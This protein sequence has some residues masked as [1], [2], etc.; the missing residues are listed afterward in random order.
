MEK[1]ISKKDENAVQQ[2]EAE[3]IGEIRSLIERTRGTV[4]Q[5]V[6]SALVLMNWHI[7]KR[8]NDEIL[9]NK[10]AD[11]GEKI[12]PTLSAQ[13]EAEYGR[14]FSKR[15]LF[16]MIQF[17]DQFPDFEIVSSLSRQLSWSHFV[18]I[19]LVKNELARQ[20][21]AEMCRLEGW[22]VRTLRER[23]NSMLFERTAIS[24]K[25][26]ET[27]KQD[28]VALQSDSKLTPDL[29]F[30]DPYFL[31]FLGL[32]DAYSERDL[33]TAILREIE[34]FLLEMGTGFAFVARQ[35]RIVIDGEDF[36]IDLLLYHRGLQCLVN[37]ELKIGKFE[38]A[39]KGQIELYLRWL[40]KYERLP[41][42]NPPL[43]LL[44]CTEA[45]TEQVELLRLTDSGIRIAEYLTE[46]PP[47][48]M[49]EEKLRAA[50]EKAQEK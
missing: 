29:V 41:H 27:I 12:V 48:K 22:S 18:E 40:D 2:T 16:R 31:D 24:R 37:V 1:K 34:R 19:L 20:F 10:R 13:L 28:L 46:L 45:K 47:I 30:R 7:G 11:Y 43:G 39:H 17:A 5:T 33:E 44:L 25:P 36:Y 26:E 8:I 15:N 21:Y 4:A 42:E 35:K 3:L 23:V 9:K 32:Q 38:A 49:L 50:V 6:N 14:G